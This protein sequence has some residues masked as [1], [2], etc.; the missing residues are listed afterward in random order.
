MVRKILLALLV[1][2]IAGAIALVLIARGAIGGEV[3][4]RTMEE[5]LTARMGQPVR[6]ASLGASFFPRVTIDLRGVTIGEPAVAGLEQIS[7]A[8]GLRG[9]L[10][11]RV[12]DADVIVAVGRIPLRLALDLAGAA[13]VEPSSQTAGFTIVS[14]RSFALRRVELVAGQRS[15][16][17]D[18]DAS[19]SG[20]RLEVSRLVAEAEGTRLEAEGTMS[21]LARGE[22][23]FGARAN[24]LNL[25]RLLAFMSEVSGAWSPRSSGRG[26]EDPRLR[27]DQPVA[28]KLE[29]GLSAP[30]GELG[31]YRFQS[32][33]SL[34]R[35]SPSQV[36][37]QPL[38]FRMFDGGFEGQLRVAMAGAS[39]QLMLNGEVSGMD[40]A[41]ILRE[42]RRSSAMSGQLGGTVSA[43]SS[44]TSSAEILRRVRGT[45]QIAIT[46]GVIPGLEMV[47]SIVLAFGKP[48]GL[49]PE[50]SGSAFTRLA[51][52]FSLDNQ[53]LRTAN[54]TFASRDFDMAGQAVIGLPAGTIDMRADVVLSRELTAQAGTDLRRV[55]QEDGRVVVPAR[56]TGTVAEPRVSVDPAAALNRAVQNEIKRK[57]Q[58]LFKRIIR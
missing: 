14:V 42:T 4:R 8:T 27:S 9:L 51:G 57:L 48:S 47:R 45:G 21:S 15:L 11:R 31:G 1:L 54:L 23:R 41:V 34:V 35:L 2:A 18:L 5:Q 22:G 20:D 40:V 56:I 49:P 12:E 6:I 10:S 30:A 29:V 39:P 50:G 44:G 52:T 53:T 24:H 7:I 36:T 3:V 17:V 46:D 33:S 37:M 19:L 13:S 32:F 16:H 28:L 55:A 43:T 25:D 26:S 58:D 38:E